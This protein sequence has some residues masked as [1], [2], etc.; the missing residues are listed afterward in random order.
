MTLA[1]VN[2]TVVSQTPTRIVVTAAVP[3]AAT[4][5][6]RGA[7]FVNS[8]SRGETVRANTFTY[9]RTVLSGNNWYAIF[10]AVM[11]V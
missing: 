3:P 11:C 8:T 6:Q 4:I 5:N 7:V 10:N 1:G 9:Q 2:A